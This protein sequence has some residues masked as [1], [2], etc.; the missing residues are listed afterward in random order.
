M[1][2]RFL[3]AK[4]LALCSMLAATTALGTSGCGLVAMGVASLGEPAPHRIGIEG[5]PFP[6]VPFKAAA[7]GAGG[8]VTVQTSEYLR[9]ELREAAVTVELQQLRPGQYQLV[10]TVLA[11]GGSGAFSRLPFSGSKVEATTRKV[12]EQ[13]AASGYRLHHP[14]KESP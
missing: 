1:S 4:G 8:V 6:A 10:G 2:D 11:S 3:A 12:A 5:E 9:A 14:T 13:I 7:Q